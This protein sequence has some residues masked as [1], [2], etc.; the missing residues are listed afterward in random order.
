MNLKQT[1][2]KT[3]R[4]RKET[5]IAARTRKKGRERE[6]RKRERGE[7]ERERGEREREVLRL[8]RL[9]RAS[10]TKKHSVPAALFFIFF[11]PPTP[12]H[13]GKKHRGREKAPFW[14]FS[15]PPPRPSRQTTIKR[16]RSLVRKRRRGREKEQKVLSNSPFVFL[17]SFFFV[18]CRC[19]SPLS[20]PQALPNFFYPIT[21]IAPHIPRFAVHQFSFCKQNLPGKV[22]ELKKKGEKSKRRAA[23]ALSSLKKKK[24]EFHLGGRRGFS[25]HLLASKYHAFL[26]QRRLFPV[27]DKES[28]GLEGAGPSLSFG[29]RRIDAGRGK[30]KKLPRRLVSI[31]SHFESTSQL[32]GT[33]PTSQVRLSRPSLGREN[34]KW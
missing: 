25:F 13:N 30:K 5:P 22:L 27:A 18:V 34:S 3:P 1:H 4:T 23:T 28:E 7:K 9:A 32:Q 8:R 16:Q 10:Q 11:S 29:G 26:L 17:F 15:V 24:K 21:F 31:A 2:H 6:G 14:F 19:P 12:Y 20:T 33:D